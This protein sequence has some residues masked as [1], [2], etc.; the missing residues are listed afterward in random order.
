MLKRRL[1]NCLLSLD[2]FTDWSHRLF[3]ISLPLPLPGS[4]Q[5]SLLR[6]Y[7]GDRRESYLKNG[8]RHHACVNLQQGL[9]RGFK[10]ETL[11]WK[12][13]RSKYQ[14]GIFDIRTI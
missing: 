11:S 1:L 8:A 12:T 2:F 9:W 6:R 13:T 3:F 7:I 5:R 14:L 4:Y 10:H